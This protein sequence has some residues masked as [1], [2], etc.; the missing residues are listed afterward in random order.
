[1]S[2]RLLRW[3]YAIKCRF[4]PGTARPAGLPRNAVGTFVEAD[5]PKIPTCVISF[6]DKY[7]FHKSFR[8]IDRYGYTWENCTR[9][10]YKNVTPDNVNVAYEYYLNYGDQYYVLDPR[11]KD[12]Y[13]TVE[14][15]GECR[16]RVAVEVLD[17]SYFGTYCCTD[18]GI[19]FVSSGRGMWVYPHELIT[20]TYWHPDMATEKKELPFWKKLINCI[21]PVFKE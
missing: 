2:E 13:V 12:K 11:D 3:G 14:V 10:F 7:K 15:R 6:P 8:Y 19:M 17:K 1:M 4:K 21:F 9:T 20:I 16:D 5:N 18:H